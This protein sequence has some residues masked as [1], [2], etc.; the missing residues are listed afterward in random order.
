MYFAGSRAVEVVESLVVAEQELEEE[1]KL[2]EKALRDKQCLNSNRNRGASDGLNS[3][4]TKKSFITKTIRDEKNLRRKHGPVPVPIWIG[5]IYLAIAW[6]VCLFALVRLGQL[7]DACEALDAPLGT[8]CQRAA[9]PI[10]D[11]A[12][13][14]PSLPDTPGLCACNVLA[15]SASFNVTNLLT[16]GTPL[17]KADAASAGFNEV[18]SSGYY[19]CQNP[20]WM[21]TVANE[22][23]KGRGAHAAQY[24]HIIMIVGLGTNGKGCM[25]NNTHVEEMLVN[26]PN[27]R[28][29]DLR[30]PTV[31]TPL[32][33]PPKAFNRDSKMMSLRLTGVNVERI[34]SEI[35]YLS[36]T[37]SLIVI[38][39]VPQFKEVPSELGRL[40]NL[41]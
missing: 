33:L 9:Y 2:E 37:I 40:T 11:M 23:W 38:M 30:Y 36:N 28:L 22:M 5:G 12:L 16:T 17:Q 25:V 4:L 34:P 32:K 18:A 31:T 21:D 3:F 26:L 15:A 8:A 13:P 6:G 10:F 35:G 24:A 14:G 20:E 29:F 41:G 39:K 7:D 27:L 19:N 1:E